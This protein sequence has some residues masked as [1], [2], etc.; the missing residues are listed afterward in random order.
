MKELPNKY[1][2]LDRI[3][4]SFE[5]SDLVTSETNILSLLFRTI[6]NDYNSKP[7]TWSNFMNRYLRNERNNIPQ[8][9]TARSSEASNLNRALSSPEMPFK[10]FMKGMRLMNPKSIDFEMKIKCK[11]Q[12]ENGVATARTV[13]SSVYLTNDDLY[14]DYHNVHF[15]D[16]YNTLRLLID[17]AFKKLGIYTEESTIT[18]FGQSLF[19]A[20]CQKLADLIGAQKAKTEVNYL[21]KFLK[22]PD[23]SVKIFSKAL[24]VIDPEY[25]LFTLTIHHTD[26]RILAHKVKLEGSG[27]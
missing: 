16:R 26:D 23:I 2:A 27:Q 25:A 19:D 20:Y 7:E 10:I 4:R 5:L 17:D 14:T 11:K 21:I 6:K 3:N 15:P 18:P 24:E 9:S 22:N 12:L 8:N 13:K 1:D